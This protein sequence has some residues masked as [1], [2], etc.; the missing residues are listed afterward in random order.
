V[1]DGT[2]FGINPGGQVQP[3]FSI[4]ADPSNANLVYVA[5]DRQPSFDEASG[6]NQFPNSIGADNYVG[7]IFRVDAGKPAKSQFASETNSSS[8]VPSGWG[9]KSNSA[10][11]ADSRSMAFDAAGN[12]I[13][14]DDG[15]IYRRTNPRNN[16]GDWFSMNGNLQVTEL[17]SSAYD[18]NARI[19]IGGAQDNGAAQQPGT[20][21]AN[22]A[23]LFQGDG[24]VVATR[25]SGTAGIWVRYSSYVNLGEPRLRQTYDASNVLQSDQRF[26]LTVHSAQPMNPGCNAPLR[27]NAVDPCRVLFGCFNGIYESLDQGDTVSQISTSLVVNDDVDHVAM[28]YGGVIGGVENPDLIIVGSG[29]ELWTRTAPAPAPFA[30]NSAYPGSLNVNGL[31][32]DPSNAKTICTADDEKIFCSVNGGA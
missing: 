13:E 15:G 30:R 19:I 18:T 29:N 31:A 23:Q 5:G 2:P 22:W 17:H 26:A 8:G 7:R 10:P 27:T 9:T 1:E 32:V 11:H 6:G 12:L 14:T 16:S 28:A 24:A 4:V 21:S 3:N 25:P 20:G